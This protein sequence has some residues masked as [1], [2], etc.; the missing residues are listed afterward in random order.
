MSLSMFPYGKHAELIS[1]TFITGNFRHRKTETRVHSLL[2][3]TS[4]QQ[5]WSV[6]FHLHPHSLPIPPDCFK[7]NPR[8][9]LFII[10]TFILY[11]ETINFFEVLNSHQCCLSSAYAASQILTILERFPLT[12]SFL[13]TCLPKSVVCICY[14]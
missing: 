10:L 8:H 13:P 7:A 6:L 1:H 14:L 2:T 11:F 5:F 3:I 12:L 9:I 4:L